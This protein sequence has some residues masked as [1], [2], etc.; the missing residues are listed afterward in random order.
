VPGNSRRLERRLSEVWNGYVPPL[1]TGKK[2]GLPERRSP[3]KSPT[4]PSKE[5]NSKM[6][7]ECSEVS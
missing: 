1:L 7:R 2:D 6:L 4:E 3:S 5:P